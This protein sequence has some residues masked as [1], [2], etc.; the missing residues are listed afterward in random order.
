M[1]ICG[2]PDSEWF[3]VV[4]VQATACVCVFVYVSAT[5]FCLF[6]MFFHFKT[7]NMI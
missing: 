2:F 5:G 1:R 3:C 4:H 6:R 7:N